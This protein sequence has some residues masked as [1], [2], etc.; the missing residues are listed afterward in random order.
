M[1]SVKLLQ[2]DCLEL[3]KDI[4]DGS[5]D[6][7]ITD[8]PYGTTHAKWDKK[9]DLKVFFSEA[10][11]V[12]KQ[13]GALACFCQLPFGVDLI[14]ACRK[15]FRYEIIWKKSISGGFLNANKMPLRAHENI[16]IFYRK[17][18]VFNKQYTDGKPYKQAN[19]CAKTS[20][21]Y[22]KQKTFTTINL[23]WRNPIDVLSIKSDRNG[24]HPTQK[25]VELMEWLVKTYTNPGD[26]VLDCFMGSGTTGRACVRN[27][28]N[29]IGMELQEKYFEIA[30]NRIEGELVTAGLNDEVP[31][32]WDLSTGEFHAGGVH[33][34]GEK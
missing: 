6:C 8:P 4:P 16:F 33:L 2:G 25:P 15:D 34:N 23:G 32:S 21:L 5:V 1:S 18:P 26:T 19:G 27:G 31:P 12:L 29:F 7:I 30:K 20:C 28:R 22:G 24:D 17:L 13:N 11:R 14:N 3:M 9:V 10:F